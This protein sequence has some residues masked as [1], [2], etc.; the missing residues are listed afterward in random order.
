[1]LN[2]NVS[3]TL[4]RTPVSLLN[5]KQT[6]AARL[7]QAMT[8]EGI[9]ASELARRASVSRGAVSQW[10]SS[11]TR[12]SAESLIKV[13]AALNVDPVWLES[14]KEAKPGTK[15][16]AANETAATYLI[17]RLAGALSPDENELLNAFRNANDS[18]RDMLLAQARAILAIRARHS[19]KTAARARA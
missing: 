16:L 14:G 1:M 18:E 8:Q 13:A 2:S 11:A 4:N 6:I 10:I 12:L 9:K 5:M 15:T 19:G 3:I 17:D 7:K